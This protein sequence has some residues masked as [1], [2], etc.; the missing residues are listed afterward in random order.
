LQ[1]IIR[2]TGNISL[3]IIRSRPS[4]PTRPSAVPNNGTITAE[5][6]SRG[7]QHG[8]S[9]PKTRRF[10]VD[11]WF[12]LSLGRRHSADNRDIPG[13]G[14]ALT[15]SLSVKQ[16]GRKGSGELPQIRNG[17]VI[18]TAHL[19]GPQDSS[20]EGAL[21]G[22]CDAAITSS[23]QEEAV[24]DTTGGAQQLSSHTTAVAKAV[25]VSRAPSAEVPIVA[26]S[27]VITERPSQGSS[28]L[29]GTKEKTSTGNTVV[30]KDLLG[31]Y[32]PPNIATVD[33]AL[34]SIDAAGTPLSA[35]TSPQA[36]KDRLETLLKVSVCGCKLADVQK[37]SLY[38]LCSLVM[39]GGCVWHLLLLSKLGEC[40][41]RSAA[42]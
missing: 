35:P 4:S 34:S 25:A 30:P 14:G 8:A 19:S 39:P 37:R 36:Q 20:G 18:D 17:A 42:G 1:G 16:D 9:E 33:V 22:A 12:G 15:G 13:N 26:R 24:L 23:A 32:R 2:E 31:S 40:P 28:V 21:A 10:S 3:E 41:L 29:G 38:L 5:G 6:S 7:I 27:S 11:S